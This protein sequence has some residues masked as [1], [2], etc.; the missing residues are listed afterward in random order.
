MSSNITAP[1]KID[2]DTVVKPVA[3]PYIVGTGKPVTSFY[4]VNLAAAA[5][6]I[7]VEGSPSG[8][9]IGEINPITEKEYTDLEIAAEWKPISNGSIPAGALSVLQLVGEDATYVYRYQ[10]VIAS[11]AAGTGSFYFYRTLKYEGM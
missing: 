1:A 7:V 10:R 11:V 5:V 3:G 2:V 4:F 9:K 8:A 6:V